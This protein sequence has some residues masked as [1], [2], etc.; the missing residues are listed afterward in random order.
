[1]R[2]LRSALPCL[3]ALLPWLGLASPAGAATISAGGGGSCT[4]SLNGEIEEGDAERLKSQNVY[5]AVL[6][7]NS[8]GGSFNEAIDALKVVLDFDMKTHVDDGAQCYSACAMIFLA[9]ARAVDGGPIPSRS[10]HV[11][12]KLGLHAPYGAMGKADT[13]AAAEAYFKAGILAVKGATQALGHKLF[14]DSLRLEMLSRLGGEHDIFEIDTLDKVGRWNIF[15]TGYRSPSALT[16]RMVSQGCT[17]ENNWSNDQPSAEI[18]KE[19]SPASDKTRNGVRRIVINRGFGVEGTYDCIVSAGVEDGK[20]FV[21]VGIDE[22]SQFFGNPGDTPVWYL[23]PPETKLA[24]M[25]LGSTS[26]EEA[27]NEYN[28]LVEASKSRKKPKR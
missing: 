20:L 28:S 7:L 15:L 2:T 18:D 5:G 4:L 24:A 1:M 10:M 21:D 22:A 16:K 26:D 6:C 12:A 23:L 13:A 3:A 9:G 27:V 19:F 11:R 8:P 25:E 17:N 14:P